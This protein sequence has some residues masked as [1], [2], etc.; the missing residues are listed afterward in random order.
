MKAVVLTDFGGPE[1]LELREVPDPA[2]GPGQV[3][4][5]PAATSVNP[6]DVKIRR[7]GGPLAPDLPGILGMDVA[8][9]V[10]SVGEGVAGAP[11]GRRRLRRGLRHRGRRQPE[12]GH[13]GRG[14][15]LDPRRFTLAEAGE[16]HRHLESG[17]AVGKVVIDVSEQAASRE[18]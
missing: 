14:P 9:V 4:V 18:P 15:L 17:Q 5:R 1:H 11:D 7:G 6:A 16:A 3:I 10:E 13:G 12:P 2:A 8:G